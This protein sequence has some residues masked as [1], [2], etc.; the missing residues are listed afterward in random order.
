MARKALLL[1]SIAI[2]KNFAKK[3]PKVSANYILCG[4]NLLIS[5]SVTAGKSENFAPAVFFI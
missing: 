5:E 4:F 2:L 3:K 1:L